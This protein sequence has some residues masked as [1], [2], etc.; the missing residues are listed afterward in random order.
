MAPCFLS[1]KCSDPTGNGGKY[2]H[3]AEWKL[4]SPVQHYFSN[5]FPKNSLFF[6]QPARGGPVLAPFFVRM[7]C[8]ICVKI[9]FQGTEDLL[10]GLGTDFPLFICKW[11]RSPFPFGVWG[12]FKKFLTCILWKPGQWWQVVQ[13][14]LN[15][16]G[17][18]QRVHSWREGKRRWWEKWTLEDAEMERQSM[19]TNGI[20]DQ[21]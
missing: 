17:I 4:T 12:Y 6:L 15:C 19:D 21:G 20:P 10:Q 18:T 2:F 11:P 5:C 13:S 16:N 9:L 3:S 7:L 14:P 8:Y 1:P